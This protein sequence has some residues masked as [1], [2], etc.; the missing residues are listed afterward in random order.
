MPN[1]DKTGPFGK[2]PMTGR[3]LGICRKGK[4]F[5]LK[6]ISPKIGKIKK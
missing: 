1:R 6:P 2:G 3:G 5:N 4:S